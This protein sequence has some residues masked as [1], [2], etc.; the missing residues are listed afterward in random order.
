[1]TAKPSRALAVFALARLVAMSS[2]A[3]SLDQT[4][5]RVLWVGLGS[6][7][8]FSVR[9]QAS[10]TLGDA[11]SLP[12]CIGGGWKGTS[13]IDRT[14]GQ[15]RV[16]SRGEMFALCL[17]ATI[18]L[19]FF[20]HTC[21]PNSPCCSLKRDECIEWA[22]QYPC[23]TAAGQQFPDNMTPKVLKQTY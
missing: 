6:D 16:E 20:G 10:G 7:M 15:K 9:A 18:Q 5:Y 14:S 8:G 2:S 1:M 19:R 4:S 11:D 12:Q 21:V 3:L 23:L 13:Q 22:K 17:P